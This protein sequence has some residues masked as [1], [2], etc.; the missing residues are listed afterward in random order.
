MSKVTK[1]GLIKKR[2]YYSICSKNRLID[3]LENQAKEGYM[4]E[5]AVG[6]AYYFRKAE[7]CE[8]KFAVD[9]FAKASIHDTIP[10]EKTEEYIEYCKEAGWE[11]VCSN[12][13]VQIFYS[14]EKDAVD[15]ESDSKIEL[16]NINRQ[17]FLPSV[18]RTL[19]YPIIMLL[20]NIWMLVTA[21][22]YYSLADVFI[23]HGNVE[24][25][26]YVFIGLIFIL[27]IIKIINFNKMNKDR[28]SAGE[29]L[30]YFSDQTEK[31]YNVCINALFV[32]FLIVFITYSLFKNVILVA[33]FIPT[34]I[35][36]SGVV[37]IEKNRK[38]KSKMSRRGNMASSMVIAIVASLIVSFITVFTLVFG[39][40]AGI[41]LEG[42]AKK[43]TYV[44]IESK[45]E[46]TT[47]IS[48]DKLPF[49]CE[50]LNNRHKETKYIDSYICNYK[51]IFGEYYECDESQY[52]KNMLIADGSLRYEILK[53]RFDFIRDSYVKTIITT[54]E[55]STEVEESKEYAKKWKVE[56]V[57]LLKRNSDK[58]YYNAIIIYDNTVLN[59]DAAS[60]ECIK[61]N[62][63]IIKKAVDDIK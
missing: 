23:K 12:G 39:I 50:S 7:P 51:T 11:Y 61:N 26:A 2:V 17:I 57:Y 45:E 15:I 9:I 6:T 32:I 30:L 63:D 54:Q 8:V 48:Q 33:V 22:K 58:N 60:R 34:F 3:Y 19:Y 18:I 59:I 41:D 25:L 24:S 49:G 40:D 37:L 20:L 53:C 43:V 4:L 14:K 16:S 21:S 5:K 1:E 55:D 56:K 47:T 13:K 28:V 42:K 35:I 36:V 52:D 46:M 62:M 27:N 31:I 10:A 38:L 44:D 29:K